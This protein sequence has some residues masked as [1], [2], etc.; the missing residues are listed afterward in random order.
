MKR[1]DVILAV[2]AAG[3]GLATLVY[4]GPGRWFIRGH[5]GD[6]AATMFVL[7]ALGLT[8]WSLRTRALV[9]L[10]IAAVIELGQNLWSGGLILG[11]VFDPWDL[12]AY[13]VGVAIAVTYHLAHDDVRREVQGQ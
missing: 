8:T 9:T 13:V 6:V 4:H 3:I 2:L 1:R 5:V 10:G 11:S 12:A 7:A